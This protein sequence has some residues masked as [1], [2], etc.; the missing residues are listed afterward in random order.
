METAPSRSQRRADHI[1]APRRR[2]LDPGEFSRAAKIDGLKR[3]H[4]LGIRN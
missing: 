4:L 2:F 3:G 1:C